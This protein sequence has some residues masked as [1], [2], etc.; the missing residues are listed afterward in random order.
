MKDMKTITEVGVFDTTWPVGQM[1]QVIFDTPI[2]IQ[3][4][5]DIRL[6]QDKTG[7]VIGAEEGSRRGGA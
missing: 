3:T 5:E 2:N 6:I 7:K 1:T 4:G